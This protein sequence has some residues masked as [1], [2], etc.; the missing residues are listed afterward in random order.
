MV[1]W[2]H[3]QRKCIQ[4]YNL[5]TLISGRILQS[6]ITKIKHRTDNHKGCM[7]HKYDAEAQKTV[8]AKAIQ[9]GLCLFLFTI[10]KFAEEY[11]V[12][13]IVNIQYNINRDQKK[14]LSMIIYLQFRN[15]ITYENQYFVK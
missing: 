9:S 3:F 1:L 6:R 11:L 12:S 8:M 7:V 4:N 5:D 15:E 14:P 2:A 10:L 13:T